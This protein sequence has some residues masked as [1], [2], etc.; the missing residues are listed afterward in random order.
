MKYFK[1]ISIITAVIII[2]SCS[3]DFLER[4]PLDELSP[5]DFFKNPEQLEIYANR[6]YILLPAHA[7]YSITFWSEKNSDNLVPGTFDPRLGGT[8]SLPTSAAEG[9]WIWDEIRQAN[10]FLAYCHKAEGI[11]ADI[12]H[13]IGEVRFFRAFLYFDK[14]KIFG[15]VPW[16]NKPLNTTSEELYTSRIS[17]RIIADSII[18]DLDFAISNLKT[19]E[20]APPFRINKEIAM[21]LKAR[22]CLY[23]GTWEKCHS[24]TVFG[25]NGSDGS[26][27]IQLAAETANLLM[28]SNKYSIYK[29]PS[30]SEY[31]SLFNQTDYTGNPEVMLWKKFDIGLGI[32]NNVSRSMAGGA[33]DLGISKSLIDSY[34]CTDGQP[35]SV[36]PLFQGRDSLEME[37]ANRDPRLMQSIFLKG[38]DQIINAPGTL[39]QK[40]N[41]PSID[42]AGDA[43]NTTGYAI[44]KG[45]NPEYSQQVNNLNGTTGS[46][47]FR[48]AEALLIYAEAK[49]ELQ[50]ITQ[51]DLDRSINLIRDRVGMPDLVLS[52]IVTDPSWDFPSL[53]PVINE[54]RRERRIELMLEGQR[55]DDLARWRAHNLIT[56]KRP[57]GIKYIGTNLEG[58]YK[59]F[60]GNPNIFVG[61]NLF[62]DENG[63]IDP[64]QRV[65]PSGYGF[66]PDRDYLSPIPSDEITLNDKLTQNPGW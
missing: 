26:D 40:Y 46:V 56:G 42:G 36:S 27:L 12:N 2:I 23:E 35:V 50:T 65:L 34:L 53:S 52:N 41:L 1:F 7:D 51:E 57:L 63:F 24:G 9:G 5:N 6:F 8:R 54:V 25:V 15:D 14:L 55:W 18:A 19:V 11:P 10:Y 49:A 31:G 29:G 39:N 28:Q 13:Y 59:D 17:R 47:I 3:E 21:L 62:V 4:Y 48:Y 64:Y 22:V 66:D 45:H 33:G 20:K 44:L 30:G 38:Y 43:R 32:A 61:I 60:L 58:A 16:I 37:V